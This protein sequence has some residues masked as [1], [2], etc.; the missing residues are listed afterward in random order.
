MYIYYNKDKFISQ[1]QLP[2]SLHSTRPSHRP[3]LYSST[4]NHMLRT[5]QSTLL[6]V[7]SVIKEGNT[8]QRTLEEHCTSMPY[9]ANL[10]ASY[11]GECVRAYTY[12][13]SMIPNSITPNTTPYHAW[14]GSKPDVSH[15]WICQMSRTL[16]LV[17]SILNSIFRYG[18]SCKFSF[19]SQ[20]TKVAS[21]DKWRHLL[22]KY[23]IPV[24]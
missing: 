18:I 19:L 16:V 6:R 7:H 14:F 11:M 13:W 23:R 5:A 15:T 9:Q 1:F 20:R 17:C 21:H 3:L 24:S 10:P 4:T 22:F 12:A 8:C 2:Q